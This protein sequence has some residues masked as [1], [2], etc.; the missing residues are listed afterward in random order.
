MADQH[1]EEN[2]ALMDDYS[3]PSIDK[4]TFS[5]KMPVI[6]ANHFKIKHVII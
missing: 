6:Q 1:I 5:I 2:K 4:A 3:M